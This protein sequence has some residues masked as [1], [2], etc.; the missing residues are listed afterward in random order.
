MNDQDNEFDEA[1]EGFGEDQQPEEL[2]K[3][4]G[5]D[6]QEN[7]SAGDDTKGVAGDDD[8]EQPTVP[9]ND[10]GDTGEEKPEEPA[11]PEEPEVKEEPEAPKPLTKEDVES[12][13][14]NLLNTERTSS[15][16]IESAT[17]DVL[18]AYYPDGLSNVLV[19][20]QSG[21]ELRTPQDVVEASGGQMS[22]EE[23]TQWL[24]NEQ[25]KLDRQI[26]SIRENA[27][28]IAETT[29]NFRRDAMAAVQKYEPL[30]KQFPHLQQKVF[31][32]L[33]KQVKVD[34]EKNVV[35][36]SPDVME[37]YDDYLEPYMMAYEYNKNQPATNPSNPAPAPEP[38]KPTAED[39]MDVSGDG[40]GS[41]VNDPNDFAQQVSKE[42]A[43]GL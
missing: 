33:M 28:E 39:R 42:L 43:K 16:E 40:G 37:H 19:D 8:K 41:P 26:S 9:N 13:V 38:P 14:S 18:D 4:G 29:T 34:N 12:V 1:F 15:K 3:E 25:Y 23:A 30:F 5:E 17:K 6:V 22:T 32:K 21:K 2:N 35:L 7:I 24:M 11:S 27:R 36:S 20:E 31:D 10:E